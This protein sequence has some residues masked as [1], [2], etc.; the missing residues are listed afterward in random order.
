MTWDL[1]KHPVLPNSDG[2]VPDSMMIPL[3]GFA[4][5]LAIFLLVTNF[6]AWIFRRWKSEKFES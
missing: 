5:L 4:L 3:M 6:A 1:E 2:S